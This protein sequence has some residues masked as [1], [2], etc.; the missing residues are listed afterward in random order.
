MVVET[1]G[2]WLNANPGSGRP[3]PCPRRPRAVRLVLAARVP[4]SFLGGPARDKLGFV[5]ARPCAASKVSPTRIPAPGVV[6]PV[7]VFS[8]LLYSD[9][10]EWPFGASCLW[11]GH[12]LA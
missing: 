10:G 7:R 8:L 4:M 1:D 5:H 11:K 2:S 9:V 6:F 3:S 12:R